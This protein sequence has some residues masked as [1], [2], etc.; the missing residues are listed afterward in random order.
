MLHHQVQN[1]M[2]GFLIFLI[3]ISP[4]VMLFFPPSNKTQPIGRCLPL[5]G[6]KKYTVL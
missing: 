2:W 4:E 5:K 6:V 3:V 1:V